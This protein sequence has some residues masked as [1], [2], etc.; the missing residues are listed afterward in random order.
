MKVLVIGGGGR[1]HTIVWKLK[2]SKQVEKIYSIPGNGGIAQVAECANLD[3]LDF[4]ALTR[5]VEEKNI[6]LTI[7]GPEAP[8]VAG[9]VNAFRERN[10]TIFGPD[11]K[12]AQL[13][14]SKIFAK[15]FMK[16][17]NI[18]TAN[19]KVFDNSDNALNYIHQFTNSPIHQLVVKADGL[20]AGKGAIVCNTKEQATDAVKKMMIDKVFGS[21]G[22]KIV[23]EE[24]LSGE[25]AT[26]LAFCDGETLIPMPAS[27]DHKPIFDG[28]KG[29][30]TGGM[31]A[32]APAPVVDK[33]IWQKLEKEVFNNFLKGINEEK[34]D[35]RGIIYFGLMITQDGPKV[36]EFNCRYG[37]PE[38]QVTLPLV[39]EDLVELT[40]ATINKHL[41]SKVQSPKSKVRSRSAVCVVLASKGYP[42]EYEK[43]KEI[44]G[45]D[46]TEKINQVIVF[47]AGT[48][49]VS[50]SHHVTV[51]PVF[52]TNGG[53]VLGVTGV[54]EDI[55][56]AIKCVYQAVEKIKFEGM[57]Y[58]KDIGAKALRKLGS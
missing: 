18:P 20:A 25:E 26:V 1:E 21:A 3:V 5:F 4:P 17:Y 13:E 39:E 36:L 58:R 27:Q 35:Y 23:I 9:I 29:P 57:H 52:L 48:R 16:K 45:L 22:E 40:E 54:N 6:D 14:G 56:K 50:P 44:F 47:H 7:V 46:E 10:L 12:S 33:E 53:R 32:Y 38:A 24:K 28:D 2:Q 43:G 31:G 42:G 19:F 11:K 15:N 8:L 34:L 55:E 30:N 51:S 49:S 41:R 37:D